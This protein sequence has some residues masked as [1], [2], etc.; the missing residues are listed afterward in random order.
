MNIGKKLRSYRCLR[1]LSQEELAGRAEINE[2]YYGKIERN[3]S[4]PTI[5]KL[6]QICKALDIDIIEFFLYDKTFCD[7]REFYFNQQIIQLVINALKSGIDIHFNRDAI[8]AGCEKSIWY[9]GF[10][11]SMNF[12]EF[13]FQ[14]F[15]VGN[16]RGE[17]FYKW[18]KVL[19][20]NK[21]YIASDL[22]KY[23]KDDKQLDEIIEYMAFD[24]DILQEKNG[25]VFFITE[26]NWLSAQLINNNNGQVLH[27]DI[28]LDK[29]KIF[30]FFKDQETLIKYIF[31][32][33]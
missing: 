10:I 19:D 3:E 17:L 31:E 33:I 8:I 1:N 16:I 27:S 4:C 26:S 11:G 7:K 23:I 14:L 22:K 32:I 28:I 9:N 24:E 15:A 13:E 20:F 12:D 6:L 18:K 29:D 2:K 5:D 30:D 21:E 25:N